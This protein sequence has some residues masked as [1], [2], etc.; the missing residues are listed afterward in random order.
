M[1]YRLFGFD[2]ILLDII[3]VPDLRVHLSN[4]CEM[5]LIKIIYLKWV[6]DSQIIL[7]LGIN[8]FL[9][10]Y[11]FLWFLPMLYIIL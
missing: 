6:C 9:N 11:Y 3:N 7:N 8:I 1:I 10:K 4:S 2:G 5:N